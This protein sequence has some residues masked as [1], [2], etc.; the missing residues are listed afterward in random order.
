MPI[1]EAPEK[2]L[3]TVEDLLRRSKG[4]L[5][6]PDAAAATGLSLVDI[7]DALARLIEIYEC[8][9]TVNESTGALQFVFAYPLRRHGQK[10]L[11]ENLFDLLAWCWKIFKAIY[12]AAIGVILIVYTVAFVIL[13]LGLMIAGSR[14]GKDSDGFGDLIGGLFRAIF[15]GIRLAAWTGLVTR[16]EPERGST[17]YKKFQPE[18]NKGKSFIQSVYSFVFGP[19]RPPFDPLADAREA[20]AFIRKNRGR[21]TAGHIIALAG[22]TYD[23]AEALMAE[24]A[25]RFRGELEIAE[26]G[27]VVGTYTELLESVTPDL[28]GGVIE[29]Y[30]D[31]VEPPYEFTG[32]S[33]GRNVGI[34]CM[35]LFNLVMSLV[36][37]GYFSFEMES[38]PLALALGIF[39][40]IFSVLFFAIPIGRIPFVLGLRQRRE[41]S[42]MRKRM[43][44][45]IMAAA[46]AP[47]SLEGLIQAKA[48]QPEE[49][50]LARSV[51]EQLLREMRGHLELDPN[52]IVLYSFPRLVADWAA[53]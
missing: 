49:G 48:V 8:R 53:A 37:L 30:A 14:G 31:E 17:R 7:K 51:L 20:A 47:L 43:V 27:T 3:R 38:V 25:V 9:V 45:A 10:T 11:R 1:L 35:N 28:A 24:Y 29:Y 22:P 16:Y 40:L 26:S 4:R 6:P 36:G 32:N 42:V 39:P 41:R 46:P 19:E 13:L 12:K 5:S 15:E 2:V 21:L 23:R 33:T 34:A 18:P 52:G 44:R 50:P